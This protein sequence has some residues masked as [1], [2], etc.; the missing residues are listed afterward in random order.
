MPQQERLDVLAVQDVLDR[1]TELTVA[2]H[3]FQVLWG[4]SIVA[5]STKVLG[6]IALRLTAGS[7]CWQ[8]LRQRSFHPGVLVHRRARQPGI[9]NPCLTPPTQQ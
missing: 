5:S 9:L 8:P 2:I 4:V 7:R 6:A 1:R 3:V